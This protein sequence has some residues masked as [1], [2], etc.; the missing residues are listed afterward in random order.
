[1][2]TMWNHPHPCIVRVFGAVD[3]S[4]QHRIVL[5]LMKGGSVREQ[6]QHAPG[7]SS[8]RDPVWLQR[9]QWLVNVACGVA[10]L[11]SR[12]VAHCVS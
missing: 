1:V 5:E 10:Y 2:E 12:G 4:P 6:L 3:E 11:H 8:Q 7:P 9:I